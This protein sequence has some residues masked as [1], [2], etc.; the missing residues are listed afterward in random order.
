MKMIAVASSVILLSFS[1]P[2]CSTIERVVRF[3]QVP[4]RVSLSS[5]WIFEGYYVD[6]T[7]TSQKTLTGVQVKY[8]DATGQQTCTQD[9]GSIRAGETVRLDP[10]GKNWTVVA[11]ET[12][13]ISSNGYLSRTYSTNTLIG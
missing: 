11:N 3:T 10:S 6:L 9:V 5:F 1:I 8:V 2:S 12:I 4:V 7:N 13:E